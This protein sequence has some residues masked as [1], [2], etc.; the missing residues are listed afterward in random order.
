CLLHLGEQLLALAVEP[1]ALPLPNV[2][3]LLFDL[4]A[5]LAL[6][7]KLE[8]GFA[9]R[10]LQRVPLCM[11]IPQ[12]LFAARR[13]LIQKAA[14]ALDHLRLDAEASGDG[15]RARRTRHAQPQMERRRQ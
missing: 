14:G 3:A 15:Q 8:L 10:G 9:P 6:V 11:Q 5:E 4:P 13:A 7:P 1:R 12:E 2:L